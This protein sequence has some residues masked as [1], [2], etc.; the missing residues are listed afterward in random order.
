MTTGIAQSEQTVRAFMDALNNK[1]L[2]AVAK[3]LADDVSYTVCASEVPGAGTCRGPQVLETL[4]AVFSM[5]ED[6]PRSEIL[7]VIAAGRWVVAESSSHGRLL[8]GIEYANQYAHIFEIADGQILTIRV[9]TDTQ[10]V[11]G[12]MAQSIA[13]ASAL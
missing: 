6:G 8:H 11:V 4:G 1:D 9:Y 3:L 7:S 10:H 2:D 13:A 12:R 5:F